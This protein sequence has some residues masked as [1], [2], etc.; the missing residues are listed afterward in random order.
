MRCCAHL[1][2]NN[3]L[4]CLLEKNVK[5]CKNCVF[6]SPPINRPVSDLSFLN[7]S[8][9]GKSQRSRF[10]PDIL[11][12]PNCVSGPAHSCILISW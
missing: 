5:V 12:Q 7:P 1:V 11:A 8:V 10:T 3:N 9:Q 6:K 4:Q 2:P